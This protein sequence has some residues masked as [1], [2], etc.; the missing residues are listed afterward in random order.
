MEHILRELG[1][2]SKE[3][4]YVFNKIDNGLSQAKKEQLYEDFSHFSPHFISVKTSAG[5]VDLREGI[6]KKLLSHD[7]Q[8]NEDF[9]QV[10]LE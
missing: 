6:E 7:T 1:L 4:I 10:I 5:I 2:A 9:D 8:K 3:R